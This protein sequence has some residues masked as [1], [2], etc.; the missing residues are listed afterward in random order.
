MKADKVRFD[1]LKRLNLVPSYGYELYLQLKDKH[2]IKDPSELYKILRTLKKEGYIDILEKKNETGRKRTIYELSKRGE[3]LY[4]QMV[5]ESA[6]SFV[7]LI[8]EVIIGRLT[9]NLF[10]KFHEWGLDYVFSECKDIYLDLGYALNNQIL[11]IRKVMKY[12]KKPPTIYVKSTSKEIKEIGQNMSY[13]EHI[14][15]LDEKVMIKPNTI[16]F[17]ILMEPNEKATF[18]GLGGAIDLLK[19]SGSILVIKLNDRIKKIF[20]FL[21][22]GIKNFLEGVFDF[23]LAEMITKSFY[24]VILPR[25]LKKNSIG[26]KEVKNILSKGFKEFSTLSENNPNRP[27]FITIYLAKYPKKNGD[28]LEN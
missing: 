12:F 21:T 9:E 7:D 15:L 14:H 11:I 8:S 20:P 19:E 26:C 18:T 1:V 3:S 28:I 27:S 24:S 13:N 17:I 23:K 22:G 25:I 4:F 5:Y 2:D 6:R 16:D 10:M